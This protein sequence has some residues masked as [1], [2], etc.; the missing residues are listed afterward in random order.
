[1]SGAACYRENRMT[2]YAIL[3]RVTQKGDKDI[4]GIM[5]Q[6]VQLTKDA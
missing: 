4:K 6:F 3:D 5:E 1:M 2:T